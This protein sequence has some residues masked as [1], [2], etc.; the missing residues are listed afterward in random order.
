M[1]FLNSE[2]QNKSIFYF[3]GHSH[4]TGRSSAPAVAHSRPSCAFNVSRGAGRS[5][6]Y[7]WIRRRGS[8]WALFLSRCQPLHRHARRGQYATPTVTTARRWV[9]SHTAWAGRA[10]WRAH[11][12]SAIARW[13]DANGGATGCDLGQE[14]GRRCCPPGAGQY[15]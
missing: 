15:D 7:S 8:P 2:Q 5:A 10:F 4:R 1:C 3:Q 9:A 6:S 14:K 11:A 12:G 13:L